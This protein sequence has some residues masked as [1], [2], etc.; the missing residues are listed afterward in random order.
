MPLSVS[1][2]GAGLLA[3]GGSVALFALFPLPTKTHN[4]G[5]GLAFQ[6]LM[7]A[8][9]WSVGCAVLAAQCALA[10]ACPQLSPLAAAGGALWAASNVL[11]TAI[12][13]CIGVG[14]A[15]LQW[16][17]AECLTGWATARFGLF[18]LAP[19]P[20]QSPAANDAGVALAVLS[21]AL[22]A[23]MQPAVAGAASDGSPADGGD[24]ALLVAINDGDGDDADGGDGESAAAA[25]AAAAAAA[26][27]ASFEA[28]G[29]DFTAALSP[30]QRRG[31]GLAASL[32]AGALSGST[33]TPPQ[34]VVDR[35]GGAT[36]LDEL[37]FSHFCGV[38]F[39]S[40]L[41]FVAYA[42]A[43]RG[44]P[45]VSPATLL[46]SYAAGL[47]WGVAC[48]LWFVTNA[49]LSIVIAFPIIT[50][51]PGV[52]TAVIGAVFFREVQGARNIALMVAAIAVYAAGAVL[53]ATSGGAA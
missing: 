29:Y 25:T 52:I 53:I 28:N 46:P 20:V 22:L 11:L 18:G 13:K 5:D 1:A 51:G 42:A 10:A 39:T 31:F 14:P 23:A 45:W 17:L 34:L 4:L 35:S 16:G 49:R 21:L 2:D 36:S 41:I 19:Q 50:I 7:C 9:I 15:M 47:C 48:T 3:A 44:R 24:A 40:T 26:A 43:T 12:V 32:V 33:F 27:A 30:Q 8:G 6:L 37:L 38:L